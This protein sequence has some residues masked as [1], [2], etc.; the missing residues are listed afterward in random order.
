MK[1]SASER[2]E[3][4]SCTMCFSFSL[5]LPLL[6]SDS[7]QSLFPVALE[8]IAYV[9]YTSFKLECHDIVVKT[10]LPFQV[11]LLIQRKK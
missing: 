7:M 4:L 9:A 2:I 3:L 8:F 10:T 11:T 1:L 5:T 6:V